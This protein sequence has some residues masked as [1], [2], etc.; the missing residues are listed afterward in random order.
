MQKTGCIGIPITPLVPQFRSEII[1]L[2][3]AGSTANGDVALKILVT[4][5]TPAPVAVTGTVMV[6]EN[7]GVLSEWPAAGVLNVTLKLAGGHHSLS[8]SYSGDGNFLPGSIDLELDVKA[9]PP[10]RRRAVHH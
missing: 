5:I 10:A 4:P 1:L 8:I 9:L 7:G 3:Y 6:T 2:V